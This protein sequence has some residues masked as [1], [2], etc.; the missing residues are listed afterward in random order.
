MKFLG[1]LTIILCMTAQLQS[2]PDYHPGY[3]ITLTHDTIYGMVKDRKE[4]PSPSIYKKVR[5]RSESGWRTRKYA[6]SQIAGYKTGDKV[7][8]SI[9]VKPDGSLLQTG[10]FITRQGRDK[11]FFRVMEKGS[12]S[13]YRLEY[14]DQESGVT[15]HISLFRRE[16]ENYL[17]RATQGIFGLR[18]NSLSKYFFDCPAL[19][20]EMEESRLKTPWDIVRYYNTNCINHRK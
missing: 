1:V 12:L 20:R 14:L 13:Y 17:I 16:H 7:F 3:I 6:P 9:A 4:A 18:K 10:F 19:V 5:F 8:E 11:R 15:D 2:K